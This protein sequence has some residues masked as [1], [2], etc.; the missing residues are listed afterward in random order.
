[1]FKFPQ[2]KNLALRLSIESPML[3]FRHWDLKAREQAN[4]VVDDNEYICEEK[5]DG[6]RTLICY[7]PEEGFSFFSRNLE[8]KY[9][10]PN[11]FTQNILLIKNGIVTKPVDWVG[12]FKKSFMLDSEVLISGN[13]DT[14]LYSKGGVETGSE[15][16]ATTALLSINAEA[17]HDIQ[18]T[19]AQLRFVIFDII[20]FGDTEYAKQPLRNRKAALEKLIPQ[21]PAEVPVE[22]NKWVAKD[23]EQFFQDILARGGEGVVFK[24]LDKP[25]L[26]TESKP[27]DVQIKRKRRVMTNGN[28][29][30]DAFISGF[31][32][33]TE[34]KAWGEQG[35]IGALKLSAFVDGVETHIASVSG[36]PLQLR[37]CMSARDGNGKPCL[38]PEFMNKVCVVSGQDISNRSLRMTHAN[39]DWSRGFRTDKTYLDCIV[40]RDELLNQV[41]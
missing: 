24:H 9:F 17:A 7:H 16:N 25:Y 15:L 1:M 34:D 26:T 30:I 18:L 39:I 5:L 3:C 12:K 11:D 32:P 20:W 29:D 10:L 8:V 38:N 2:P 37:V 31:I 22:L 41:F 4:L 33:A 19:Q 36:I 14:S 23:K 28:E 6:A 35:L 21:F 40:S 27:R 13:I